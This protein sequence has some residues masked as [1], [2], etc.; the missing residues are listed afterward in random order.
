MKRE[1]ITINHRGDDSPLALVPANNLS[2]VELYER[3]DRGN[4]AFLHY[5][6]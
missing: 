2:E 1:V 6:T 5:V 4:T 3:K